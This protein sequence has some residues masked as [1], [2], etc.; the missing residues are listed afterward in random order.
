M[1]S[2]LL[3]LLFVIIPFLSR[4]EFD[5][6][7]ILDGEATGMIHA[8]KYHEG[9]IWVGSE[10]GLFRITGNDIHHIPS[11]S[12]FNFDR[13]VQIEVDNKEQLWITTYNNGVYVFSDTGVIKHIDS[14]NGLPSNSTWALSLLGNSKM[15]VS[16]PDSLAVVDIESFNIDHII[17]SDSFSDLEFNIIQSITTSSSDTLWVADNSNRILR[18]KFRDQ[19]ELTELPLNTTAPATSIYRKQNGDLLAGTMDG[20]F[21]KDKADDAFVMS[22]PFADNASTNEIFDISVNS[23]GTTLI[24]ASQLYYIDNL[25]GNIE[26]VEKSIQRYS[27]HTAAYVSQVESLENGDFLVGHSVLGLMSFTKELTA[28]DI[29]HTGNEKITGLVSLNEKN[30]EAIILTSKGITKNNLTGS[31]NPL[32]IA[33]NARVIDADEND[34]RIFF[35]SGIDLIEYSESSMEL[36]STSLNLLNSTIK[37][38]SVTGAS[39]LEDGQYLISANGLNDYGIFIG[40]EELGYKKVLEN[41]YTTK[42]YKSRTHGFLLAT[43]Y[44]GLLESGD[45][46]EWHPVKSAS[47]LSDKNISGI[48]ED[49]LGR[50]WYFADG[51]GLSFLDENLQA[52]NTVPLE[53]IGNSRHVRSVSED[54]ESNI[55]FT[56][57]NG[58][59]RLD[60]SLEYSISIGTESGIFEQD[61]EYNG[62]YKYGEDSLIVVGDKYSYL[63]NTRL[64]NTFLNQ[65]QSSATS[66]RITDVNSYDHSVKTLVKNERQLGK[67]D[68]RGISFPYSDFLISLTFAA[69]NYAERKNL[70]FEYRLL[71]LNDAWMRSNALDG[72]ATY[73]TLPPGDY[74]FQVRVSDSRSYAEQP[75]TSLNINVLPPWWR[76]WQAYFIYAL[77]IALGIVGFYKSRLRHV[78][79]ENNE[80][81]LLV[82]ARTKDVQAS[83]DRIQR[84]LDQKKA[85]FS[86][87]SHEFRTPLTLIAGP[88]AQLLEDEHDDK[89]QS[90][91]NTIVSNASRLTHL[92]DQLLELEAIDSTTDLPVANYLVNDT[93]AFVVS[94]LKPLA[95]EKNQTINVEYSSQPQAAL[96]EDSLEKIIANLLSNAIKYT[97]RNGRIDISVSELDDEINISIADT[98]DGIAE[99]DL[100]RIFQRFTRLEQSMDKQGSGVGLAVV[101]ELVEANKG[102]INVV[103]HLDEGT[104]FSI[105]LPLGY[106]SEA[107]SAKSV[108]SQAYV[109]QVYDNTKETNEDFTQTTDTNEK[110]KTI[111]LVEDNSG[112]LEHLVS[113]LEEDYHCI[114]AS[115]GKRGFVKARD[116]IP[117]IIISDVM[118]PH[119]DGFQMVDYL[120][121]EPLTNHI[122]VIFLTA[123][124]D[125]QTRLQS[126]EYGIDDCISKPFSFCEL[127]LRIEQL[128]DVRELLKK[129]Y[130]ADIKDV[131]TNEKSSERK[132]KFSNEREQMFFDKFTLTI[133]QNFA[134][135]GFNRTAAAKMLAVSVRQLNRKLGAM[136]DHNF[137]DYLKK[138]R[139]TKARE[140]LRAGAQI[141]EV[142]YDV[143]FSTPSYF[144]NCFKNEYGISPKQYCEKYRTG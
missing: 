78:K 40:S 21:V 129:R 92:V 98:G 38:E 70:D 35:T 22:Y 102:T 112:L 76:T 121:S 59:F 52:D 139:L 48:F 17:D 5:Q 61:F 10:G 107:S 81:N 126:I 6:T 69:T 8:I 20:L 23:S 120:K 43:A 96:I 128:L 65:R 86:N 27:A 125:K 47:H 103:S 64:L 140:L 29:A 26:A 46:Y 131:L 57:T 89:K 123:K 93:V 66:V 124:G 15:V 33:D 36:S 143:G 79:F 16:L 75:I 111:L 63:I 50:V 90:S 104:E 132:I 3:T 137:N 94:S 144:S 2:R 87:V 106:F 100:D 19:I 85:L 31:I 67:I 113:G 108:M 82:D 1:L 12:I 122:P 42:L 25:T 62:I 44:N 109:D 39:I 101:K 30:D 114:A 117:D 116:I 18:I 88:A 130:A 138:Y 97:P 9:Q 134:K 77:C 119:M 68:K 34:S 56:T 105:V 95:D 141:T 49:R 133:E 41:T 24:A 74:E 13:I 45:G 37:I 58:L 118:M 127:R 110:Q 72:T 80:L 14:Q 11:S 99:S 135:E 60:K 32:L 83:R 28:I 55:W 7:K 53:L 71:G 91:L 4:A 51:D 54:S 84:L 115:D 142:S 73:S 136:I